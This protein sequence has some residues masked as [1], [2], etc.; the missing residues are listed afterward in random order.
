MIFHGQTTPTI[1]PGVA[2]HTFP[3]N[4]L[5]RKRGKAILLLFSAATHPFHP[6]TM[7]REQHSS[8]LT[9]FPSATHPFP[10]DSLYRGKQQTKKLQGWSALESVFIIYVTLDVEL[11]ENL[12]ERLAIADGHLV[13]CLVYLVV[14]VAGKCHH[15]VILWES[16]YQCSCRRNDH[17]IVTI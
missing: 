5:Y 4:L 2:T 10:P 7:Y 9:T 13:N 16:L 11:A 15:I 14:I 17:L 12:E 8:T 3:R 1:R 6:K